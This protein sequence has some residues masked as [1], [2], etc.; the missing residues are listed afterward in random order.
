MMDLSADFY[1]QTVAHG[2]PRAP[3]AA[4]AVH[5]HR[6]ER[7]EPA[8]IERT[9]LL[10]IEGERDDISGLGQT[11]AAHELCRILPADKREHWEQPGVGHY[12]LFNGQRFRSE[13]APR[14][15]ALHRRA[16]VTRKRRATARRV[17]SRRKTSRGPDRTRPSCSD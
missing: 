13:V 7:V 14:I 9:A 16:S 2:V 3:A 1:L 5:L 8:A 12:G 10:T 4:R 17:V 6:G 11:R 15:K